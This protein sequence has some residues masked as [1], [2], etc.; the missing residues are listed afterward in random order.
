L[1]D[2]RTTPLAVL[3]LVSANR[4]RDSVDIEAVCFADVLVDSAQLVNGERAVS[5]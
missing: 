1:G 3:L 5:S 4:R 2:S